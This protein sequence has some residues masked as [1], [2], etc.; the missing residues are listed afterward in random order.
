MPMRMAD[1]GPTYPDAGVIATRPA[2]A[3]LA[4]PGGGG[5]SIVPPFKEHPRQRGGS[6]GRI[7]HDEGARGQ[8]AGAD[9]AARIEPKPSEPQQTR[10]NHGHGQIMWRHRFRAMTD[11][12]AEYERAGKAGDPRANVDDR[13]A[14]KV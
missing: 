4:A 12:S 7:G 6:R 2:T 9:G 8:R 14:R 13:S 11:A 5:A 3:P 1:R 10:S